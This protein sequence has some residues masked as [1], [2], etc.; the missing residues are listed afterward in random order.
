MVV[1]TCGAST[2]L[3]TSLTTQNPG[4]R[5]HRCNKPSSCGFVAWAEPPKIQNPAVMIP[6]LLDTIKRHEENARQIFTWNMEL[7]EEAKKLAQDL[8]C[9]WCTMLSLLRIYLCLGVL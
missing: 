5:F 6:A 3:R 8:P 7:E 2:Q 4:R 1:C 9:S